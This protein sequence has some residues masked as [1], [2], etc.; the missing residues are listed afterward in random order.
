M[1]GSDSSIETRTVSLFELYDSPCKAARQDIF[2]PRRST[3]PKREPFNALIYKYYT[4]IRQYEPFLRFPK[5][6]TCF[7]TEI[8]HRESQLSSAL[9]FQLETKTPK[10]P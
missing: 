3:V 8:F 1:S 2:F 5:I 9:N 7:P 4:S 6:E 10:T